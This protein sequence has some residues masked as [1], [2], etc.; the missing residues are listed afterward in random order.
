MK[1]AWESD[2]DP[3]AALRAG[4]P[5]LFEEF[6]RTEAATFIGFFRRQG[7]ERAEAEDLAQEVFVKLFRSAPNYEH[8]G[9]FKSFAL[10][11]ARNVWVDRRRREGVLPPTRSLSEP[12]ASDSEVRLA[13]QSW[14]SKE[15]DVSTVISEREETERLLDALR[16]LPPGHA[17]VFELAVIQGW[18]YADIAAEVDIPVGTVK[19]RVF[20]AVRKLREVLEA[21]ADTE[22]REQ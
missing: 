18:A 20:N 6:V 10:R 5:A 1:G 15:R 12:H 7:A 11:V 4:N 21:S 2:R 22:E 8:R 13:R 14:V 17:I 3:L 16:T 19:S 9:A